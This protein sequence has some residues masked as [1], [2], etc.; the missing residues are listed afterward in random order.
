MNCNV[1]VMQN[2]IPVGPRPI[3]STPLTYKNKGI[4]VIGP[5]KI[6]NK[7][8]L[9]LDKLKSLKL[10]SNRFEIETELLI[11]SFKNKFNIIE[12]PV[13]RYERLYGKSKLFNIPFGRLL[14]GIRVIR[15][16][17]KGYFFWK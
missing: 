13:H 11:R 14:F 4:T 16:I 7:L 6:R 9:A 8:N 10:T 5:A 17:I 1:G 3:S 2:I 15:T 12:I